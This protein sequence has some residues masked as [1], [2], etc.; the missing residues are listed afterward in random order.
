M[1]KKICVVT[2]SRSEYGLL[3]WLIKGIKEDK[4]LQLQLVATASHLSHEFGLTY[5][6]ILEDGFLIDEKVEMLLSSDTAVG[7]SKSIGLGVIGFADAFARLKP[8]VVVLL[9]DR[10]ETLAA[11]QAAFIAK[12][13]IAH[14]HGGELTEGAYDDGI[15]HSVSK[16]SHLHFVSTAAYR[17][18]VIQLGEDPSRVFH[19]GA[20]VMD[21]ISQLSLLNRQELEQKLGLEFQKRNYVITYH[22]ETLSEVSPKESFQELLNALSEIKDASFIFTKGN[23]DS[24][25]RILNDMVDTF[26]QQHP[27][28]KAFV[29]LGHKNYLSLLSVVDMAIGNSS[30]GIIEV[31]YFK[32][33]TIN[34]GDRQR[35][36][37]K[38]ASVIDCLPEK[39]AIANAI[40]QG[41]SS[42]FQATLKEMCLPYGEGKVASTIISTLKEYDLRQS[43]K[44]QFYDISGIN[45]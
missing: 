19:V 10:F 3:Y 16:M 15:R 9:G 37:I 32:I 24:D 5:K 33:P 25:G 27:H 7:V 1:H 4:Q 23:P 41:F 42:A 44:K 2:G 28:A 22:P 26:C 20:M 21:S 8:D 11:A 34:I 14:I 39:A 30:S 12:I 18:R 38:A 13:P 35:G 45:T 6:K 36:R 29:E 43:L 40:A 31:P 17:Q